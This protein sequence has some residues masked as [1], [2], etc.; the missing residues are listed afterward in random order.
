MT[1]HDI[2]KLDPIYKELKKQDQRRNEGVYSDTECKHHFWSKRCGFCNIVLESEC[3][4][5]AEVGESSRVSYGELDT[6]VCAYALSVQLQQARVIQR[7]KMYWVHANDSKIL[8]LRCRTNVTLKNTKVVA[9]FT[10]S[11][12]VKILY[13][14]PA[15]I[16]TPETFEYIGR[17]AHDPNRLGRLLLKHAK[18]LK[19]D[20]NVYTAIEEQQDELEEL[21]YDETTT[22][23]I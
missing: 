3:Q 5:N 8:T 19:E 18:H 6:I 4:H 14:L 9:A 13:R 12:I 23:S 7:S 2:L 16:L 21:S 17:Q 15:H 20:R 10:V 1:S 22:D 11:E